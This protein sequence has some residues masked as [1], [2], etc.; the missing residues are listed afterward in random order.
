[1]RNSGFGTY[2]LDTYSLDTCGMDTYCLYPAALFLKRTGNMPRSR[3]VANARHSAGDHAGPCEPDG[4]PPLPAAPGWIPF[5]PT[6]LLPHHVVTRMP[7]PG[8][9]SYCQA[10]TT[11]TWGQ[12]MDYGN[13]LGVSELLYR[14]CE[15]W[16]ARLAAV[17]THLTDY[18]DRVSAFLAELAT[19]TV[20]RFDDLLAECQSLTQELR[21]L[22]MRVSNI[23]DHILRLDIAERR[24]TLDWEAYDPPPVSPGPGW[25]TPSLFERVSQAQRE[26]RNLRSPASAVWTPDHL[27][28]PLPY[29]QP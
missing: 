22:A 10:L 25:R 3:K 18:G 26:A 14:Q 24:R 7:P 5:T 21:T 12:R 11:E 28:S 8:L 13:R 6:S 16:H 4:P 15:P 17:E 9:L 29:T 1:M 19:G 20:D 27:R 2:G 23:E